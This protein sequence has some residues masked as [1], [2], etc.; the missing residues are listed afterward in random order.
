MTQEKCFLHVDIDAFFASVEQLDHPEWKGRPVIVGGLPGE[1][2]SVVST[3]SYEARKFGVHSA[4]PTAQAYKLCPDA[5]YTHGSYKRYSELS[6]KIMNILK[7]YSPDVKQISIDEASMDI[8]GT[9]LLFGT[10]EKIAQKIRTSVFETTGLTVSVGIAPT[11]YLAKLSSEVNKP[12]GYYR[13]HNGEEIP[14]MLNLPLEKVWGIGKKTLER[15]NRAGFYTTR[16]IYEQNEKLL[17]SL[18]GDSMGS[19]LYNTMRALETGQKSEPTRSIS[20]ETTFPQDITDMYIAETW[21]MELCHNII[22]R[23]KKEKVKSKTVMIKLRYDDFTT[24]SSRSTGEEFITSIDDL[25]ERAR[26]L[27]EK[28]YEK[29]RGIRLLGV[30]TENLIDESKAAQEVLFDF[31]EKKKKAV[32]DAILR[33]TSRH[34]EIKVKKARL[35]DTNKKRGLTAILIAIMAFSGMQKSYAQDK[36]SEIT[37]TSAAALNDEQNLIP[38]PSEAEKTLWK[39]QVGKNELEFIAGG[40]WQGQA[41]FGLEATYDNESGFSPSWSSPVFKQQVDMSLWFMMNRQWYFQAAAADEFT[42]NTVAMGFYGKEKNPLK[43]LRIANRG[44]IFPS[45]YSIDCFNRSI[46]GGENQA[47]GIYAH[48][49][50]PDN[51]RNRWHGDFALRYDMTEQHSAT[52]YGKNSVSTKCIDLHEYISGQFFVLPENSDLISC[53]NAIYIESSQG[54]YKDDYGRKFNKISEDAYIAIQARNQIIISKDAGGTKKDGKLP[55][56]I[57]EFTR[58]ITETDLGSYKNHDSFLGKIQ[59]FFGEDIDLEKFA[60]NPFVNINGKTALLVQNSAGFSP[61]VCADYYDCGIAEKSDVLIGSGT[62]GIRYEEFSAVITDDFETLAES[63]FFNGKHEFARIYTAESKNE[64]LLTPG[65]R[66]PLAKKHPGFY[67]GFADQ[68]DISLI[69]QS[70]SSIKSYNIGTNASQGSVRLYKN[71]ILDSGALY[72]KNTGIITPSFSISDIDKIY[73]TWE[74]D[75]GNGE[76]GAISA[77]ASFSYNIFPSLTADFSLATRW[78][79][80]PFNTFAEYGRSAGG[81]ATAE[82]GLLFQKESIRISNAIAATAENTNVTGLYRILGMDDRTPQTYY[83]EK[84]SGFILKNDIIPYIKNLDLKK[85]HDGTLNSENFEG[86]SDYSI[87]GFKIPL[88]WN[89]TEQKGTNWAAIN[90]KLNAGHLLSSAT[91]FRIALKN[92]LISA[93]DYD[94][95]IQLGTEASKDPNAE[96]SEKIPVWKISGTTDE[97][98]ISPF[99]SKTTGWQIVRISL[100]DYNRSCFQSY[101]DMRII[102]VSK[103]TGK[104]II[105]AGPY[106]IITQGIFTQE[107]DNIAV[108][109]EQ[110]K[111]NSMP[112]RD[113]FNS[114]D[115]YIQEIHWTPY[116]SASS[117]EDAIITCAKY[118][119]ETDFS[120]YKTI[121]FLFKYNS[122]SKKTLEENLN[123][124]EEFI[125]FTLD[126]ESSSIKDT[127][128]T[129]VYAVLFKEA[130][131]IFQ[132][133]QNLWHTFSI[134]VSDRTIAIDGIKLPESMSSVYI[135]KNVIP[136]RFKLKFLTIDSEQNT[137]TK[138]TLALDEFYLEETSTNVQIQDIAELKLEKKGTIVRSNGLQILENALFQTKQ[139]S[140]ITKNTSDTQDDSMDFSNRTTAEITV[141]SIKLHADTEF[142]SSEYQWLSS[143]SHEISTVRP[144]FEML[145]FSDRYVFDHSGTSFEKQTKAG[146]QLKRVGLPVKLEG[147]VSSTKSRWNFAT[148]SE[149]SAELLLEKSTLSMLWKN[150]IKTSQTSTPLSSEVEEAKDHNYFSGYF[151]QTKDSFSNGRGNATSRNVGAQSELS[152]KFHAINFTPGIILD[153]QEKY[154]ASGTVKYADTIS[155]KTEFPFV[156]AGQ[157]FLFTYIKDGGGNELAEDGGTFGTD[158]EKLLNH[159]GEHD[160][161]FRTIPIYEL[162]QKDLKEKLSDKLKN[163]TNYLEYK[164]E[165]SFRWKRSIFSDIKDIFIPSNLKISSQRAVIAADS[166][167]DNYIIKA[168]LINTPFNIFGRQSSLC[169]FKWY[170]TDEFIVSFTGTAKIPA[171]SPSDSDFSFSTYIQSGFYINESDSLRVGTD[172]Q[173][174]TDNSWSTQMTAQYKRKT[175][176]SPIEAICRPIGR[177]FKI[178]KPEMTRTNS[179]DVKFSYSD[180]KFSQSYELSHKIELTFQKYVSLNL[181]L[182]AGAS[183]TTEKAVLML[184]TFTLGGKIK[185]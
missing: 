183:H 149:C 184:L 126:R 116:S 108:S 120:L 106:E 142:S 179:I 124:S 164:G 125:T 114:D 70:F 12:N 51:E 67:L 140:S 61:F 158:A 89:F 46:G 19:F 60:Y 104:G 156:I 77:Q 86:T 143:A 102:A 176:F 95:Y 32:E 182:N 112:K 168:S 39:K 160:F 136:T 111:D 150:S 177:K 107:S 144:L 94:L 157:N 80:Q 7:L 57:I 148:K 8:T 72:D 122:E 103:N 123:T 131:K 1:P 101:H 41:I 138:G 84:S 117:K 130:A 29:G 37:E 119:A 96:F 181:G 68:S 139:T 55:C 85:E 11:R 66:Y 50:D 30:G 93:E 65:N 71:S 63:A 100:N 152:F 163:G 128:K 110:I 121:N 115:N 64:T 159:F 59:D 91:E 69:V 5:I 26:L 167:S 56:I 2:R 129:A 49:S 76:N 10:P 169:L 118:F 54:S 13:I 88:E 135:N 178:E 6:E 92:E 40:W 44:I 99:I 14:F 20:A 22:F 17:K 98:V 9:E 78:T 74:E 42:K 27:F 73:I 47:P 141:T 82:T 145:D 90:I 133:N 154:T 185:F 105:C 170:N 153:A 28:K 23:L 172:F 134:N 48:F 137:F 58:T 175:G 33:L 21:I 173:I 16:Q 171:E 174:K 38:L 15:L 53:I 180:E 24:I 75:S 36:A 34:P 166:G 97:S 113:T 35:L 147:T 43:E 162:F 161:I 127:G 52:Y 18:F 155:L 3:A 83:L 165:Y 81:Y 4:M 109:T 25:Y 79:V 132:K 146:L 31:G 87:T 45:G 62:T 151:S